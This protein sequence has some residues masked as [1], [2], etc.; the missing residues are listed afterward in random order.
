MQWI[1]SVTSLAPIHWHATL[2][3]RVWLRASLVVILRLQHRGTYQ[4]LLHLPVLG[5]ESVE[6]MV[7]LE[8]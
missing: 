3:M 7:I 1:R 5:H 8:E 4:D 6:I 2:R